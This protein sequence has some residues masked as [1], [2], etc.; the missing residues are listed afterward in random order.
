MIAI[1]VLT[2]FPYT[3]DYRFHYSALVV[4]G[5]AVATVEGIAWLTRIERRQRNRAQRGCCARADCRARHDGALGRVAARPRLRRASGRRVPTRTPVVQQAAIDLV[6]KDAAVSAPYNL[7][8]HLTHRA[9]VYE[10]PVPWCN[11]NW[12]VA[13]ENL[14]D[15]AGVEWL[16]LDRRLL[17]D[18][19]RAGRRP[20]QHRVHGAV[21]EP[22]HRR[23]RAH[24]TRGAPRRGSRRSS[25][26]KRADRH[27]I[28]APPST[29]TVWPV[30]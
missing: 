21:R 8:P 23:R 20:A 27:A 2:L 30:R 24:A 10:F 29:G 1:N 3:R 4:A 16:I 26:A 5:C 11:I 15:P 28:V 18:E 7:V 12:G 13:G 14:D 25:A 19:H 6:P 17:G 9:K 22:R